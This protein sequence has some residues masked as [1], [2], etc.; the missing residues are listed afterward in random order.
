MEIR[1]FYLI[2]KKTSRD[3]YERFKV[4]LHS[5]GEKSCIFK[6]SQIGNLLLGSGVSSFPLMLELL[7]YF[8]LGGGI[9]E[10]GHS[11]IRCTHCINSK[12]IGFGPGRET[13]GLNKMKT[14][15]MPVL[16]S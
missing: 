4:P 15:D 7:F 3:V 1:F 10:Q 11:S 2:R 14:A 8:T 13:G 6:A 12:M 16:G 9:S 5:L